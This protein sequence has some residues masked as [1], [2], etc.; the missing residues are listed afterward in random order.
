MMYIG[1]KIRMTGNYLQKQ[2]KPEDSCKVWKHSTRFPLFL[3]PVV[4]V[5][6]SEMTLSFDNMP[7]RFTKLTKKS[8]Y[9]H[10]YSV[11]LQK[12]TD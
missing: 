2:C 8:Y 7:E 3:P 12:Y 9:T 11:L 1:Q 4:S 5:G 6:V 10:V